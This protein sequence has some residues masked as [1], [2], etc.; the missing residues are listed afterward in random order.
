MTLSVTPAVWR[1]LPLVAVI[2]SGKVLPTVV[3]LVVTVIVE[4]PGPVTEAGL[5]LAVAANGKPPTVKSTVPLN[6]LDDAMVT[7]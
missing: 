7:V 3:G 1:R 4:E 6:P 2:V 5:K